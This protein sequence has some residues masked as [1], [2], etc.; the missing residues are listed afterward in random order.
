MHEFT[1]EQANRWDAWQH[2]NA[3][4]ARRSDRVARLFG[5]TM[6]A[7]TLTALAVAMSR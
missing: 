2:A 1:A 4:S 6:L 5:F 3:I 7:A